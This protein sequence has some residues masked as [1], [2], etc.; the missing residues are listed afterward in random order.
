MA[1]GAVPQVGDRPRDG[2]VEGAL[3]LENGRKG[4][5]NHS[6]CPRDEWS[7]RATATAEAD[8]VERVEPVEVENVALEVFVLVALGVGKRDVRPAHRL[9]QCVRILVNQS[10][11]G[12]VL[13]ETLADPSADRALTLHLRR[14]PTARF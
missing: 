8:V 14:L 2:A 7:G 10:P 6:A 4:P 13:A 3:P 9:G 11:V 1:E 12:P 5:D